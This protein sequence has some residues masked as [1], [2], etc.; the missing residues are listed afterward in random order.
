M[1]AFLISG[2]EIRHE[3]RRQ[4]RGPERDRIGEGLKFP[5]ANGLKKGSHK[6]RGLKNDGGCQKEY[7]R[8]LFNFQTQNI[9]IHVI[10]IA[11][12]K[13]AFAQFTH[14]H[15]FVKIQSPVVPID[16]EF[17]AAGAGMYFT[18]IGHGMAKKKCS[19]T[20]TLKTG[21]DINLLQMEKMLRFLLNREIAA[22]DTVG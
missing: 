12:G 21:K 4:G 18:D 16:I 10:A 19:R 13:I 9:I 5:R 3:R 1:A 8:E 2:P 6:A 11:D 7:R 15:S 20:G 22:G 17:H 14:P